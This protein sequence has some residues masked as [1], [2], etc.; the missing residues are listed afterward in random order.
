MWI[1]NIKFL[2]KS[3]D[4]IML[5]PFVL[6]RFSKD[7]VPESLLNHESKHLEQAKRAYILGFYIRYLYEYIKGR[8]SGLRHRQAYL[9]ISYEKEARKAEVVYGII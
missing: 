9:N 5:Y 2:P 3:I 6:T 4:A 1:Y 8:L 7:R